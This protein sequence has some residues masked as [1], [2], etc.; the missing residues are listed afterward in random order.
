MGLMQSL[1]RNL[2][3]LVFG[4][5][6]G[7]GGPERTH[8]HGPH[9]D[10]RSGGFAQR[11]AMQPV[12]YADYRRARRRDRYLR[13][14]WCYFSEVIEMARR[15][16]PQTVLEIGPWN[17]PLYPAG[18]TLDRDGRH[19][20]T[21]LHDARV[22]P[23]PISTGAYDLIIALQVWEHLDGRQ[24]E[25]FAELRRCGRQAILSVPY[26]WKLQPGHSHAGIDDARV[27]RWTGGFPP[28]EEILISR[29]RRRRRKI[30]LFDFTSP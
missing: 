4:G 3:G 25:A 13:H 21:H 7:R 2:Q 16:N 18:D 14:R 26:G 24:Q 6:H 12:S 8:R 15:L 29:P 19:G 30:Y 22:T 1:G 11:R 20:P 5:P 28:A 23:W 9:L 27:R 17:F 10:I